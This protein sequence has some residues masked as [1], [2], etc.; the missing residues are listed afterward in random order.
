MCI[1]IVGGRADHR[2]EPTKLIDPSRHLPFSAEDKIRIVS[3]RDSTI[4]SLF[5][6]YARGKASLLPC[7]YYWANDFIFSFTAMAQVSRYE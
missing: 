3:W 4:R 5:P 2:M 6:I 1:L 7:Y